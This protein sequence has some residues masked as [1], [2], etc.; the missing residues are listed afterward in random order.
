MKRNIIIFYVLAFL[1]GLIF[2]S[3]VSTLYRT[4]A[5]ITLGQM[6]IIEGVLSLV[7]VLCEVP[8]GII[9]DHIGYR[10]TLIISNFIYFLSKVVFFKA[11][12]F[13]MFLLE[14]VLLGISIAGLSGCDSAL[15][16][17][18]TDKEKTVGVFGKLSM[19]G[20]LGMCV[21][22]LS[23]TLFFKDNFKAAAL[24]TAGAYFIV[25]VITFFLKDVKEEKDKRE[26]ADLK[27]ILNAL[28]SIAP[29][30]VASVLLTESTHMLSTFYNQLQYERVGIPVGWYGIL[31]MFM[32][33]C[34]LSTGMLEKMTERISKEKLTIIMT[35]IACV[36]S[37][38]MIFVYSALFSVLIF[39]VLSVIETMY[40]AIL[41]TLENDSIHNL[42][43]ATV[44]SVFSLV[45]NGV[46]FF[47]DTG[48]GAAADR[49][50][51]SAYILAGSLSLIS[52]L[53]F[54]KWLK[55]R[56]ENQI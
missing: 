12:S 56:N 30:L 4:S 18:S 44:L 17:L 27:Q 26:K 10:K 50:L 51:N 41:N 43:R 32:Q 54:V 38:T 15:L 33:I 21:A 45:S 1:Q 29:L 34:A 13:S 20:T 6:G 46:I 49:S 22:S 14:R 24:W 31:Y 3:S 35:L 8:W 36:C 52:L 16:Y 47:V 25:S 28:S 53:L 2:Y 19:Y 40:F 55:V 9:C 39:A 37:F 42:P 5:G 48:F 7:A 23:F 11:N